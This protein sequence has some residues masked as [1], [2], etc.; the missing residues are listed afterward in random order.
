[1]VHPEMIRKSSIK[2]TY[3]SETNS[4]ESK[5]FR[6]L[7]VACKYKG[8]LIVVG[9]K[10]LF[11]LFP[12]IQ[13]LSQRLFQILSGC[14]DFW[15]ASIKVALW[16]HVNRRQARYDFEGE[17]QNVGLEALEGRRVVWFPNPLLKS[18][19]ELV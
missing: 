15:S 5:N 18:G 19:R 1:M 8:G 17:W 16:V 4:F 6:K 12:L 3:V 14:N 7:Q 11:K 9:L 13:T 2:R 10:N